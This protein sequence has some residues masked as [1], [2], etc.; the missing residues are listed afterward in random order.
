MKLAISG[1]KIIVYVLVAYFFQGAIA[2]AQQWVAFDPQTYSDQPPV[3]ERPPWEPQ[4]DIEE[5]H[6]PGPFQDLR[7]ELEKKNDRRKLDL[8]L[9]NLGS[10]LGSAL[11]DIFQS[12]TPE[13]FRFLMIYGGILNEANSSLIGNSISDAELWKTF[14]SQFNRTVTPVEFFQI[15]SKSSRVLFA[16]DDTLKKHA[17]VTK[18]NFDKILEG[19]KYS[20]KVYSGLEQV[21]NA[22]YLV[23]SSP[24]Y[25]A[26]P[27][28]NIPLKVTPSPW[29]L[30]KRFYIK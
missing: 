25:Y 14:H 4:N 11:Q 2:L 5:H 19:Y 18:T 13:K 23:R 16:Y 27:M 22:L 9:E 15:L 3:D 30:C 24:E 21:H 26:D 7:T 1:S 17:N 29:N 20:S 10:T 6:S 12:S 8:L 28:R